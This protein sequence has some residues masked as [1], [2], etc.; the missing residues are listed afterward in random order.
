ML[1]LTRKQNESVVI[2]QGGKVVAILTIKDI[3]RGSV[4][5]GFD[6]ESDVRIMRSELLEKEPQR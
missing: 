2:I 4:R 6:A 3:K 5:I 1:G